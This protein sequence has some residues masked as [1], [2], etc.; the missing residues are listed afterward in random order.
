MIIIGDIKVMLT[1]VNLFM[2]WRIIPVVLAGILI[3]I[4]L[5]RL[6]ILLLKMRDILISSQTQEVSQKIIEPDK[7]I[8][9]SIILLLLADIILLITGNLDASID[10]ID[11]IEFPV[12]FAV[13]LV[14]IWLGYRLSERFF[15]IYLTKITRNGGKLNEDLLLLAKWLTLLLFLFIIITIFSETHE[16]NILGLIASL[17]VGGVAIAFA[18]QKTLEQLLGGI[19]LYFDRPFVLGDYVGLPDGTFG[20]VESIG[21]RSTKIRTSGKGSL[22]VVPNN[23][24]TGINIENFTGASKIISI[25]KM[26][27]S[28]HIPET[29][30]AF[31]H[32]L[33]LESSKN[34]EIDTHSITV[35]F[36]DAINDQG[37]KIS[38]SQIKYFMQS[39][40]ELSQE[41]RF[42]VIQIIIENIHQKLL[43]NGIDVET[44]ER[45]RID[46][47]ISI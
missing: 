2:N 40:R 25:V 43:E 26:N 19:V 41:F 39:S 30:Q 38:K 8:L 27:F 24:L 15:K 9:P 45:I 34:T 3:I 6:I 18:A 22:M 46:S 37:K 28:E 16:I 23:Y 20:R 10:V 47:Q 14:I 31:I 36:E 4:A 11:I 33:I 42:K 32:Q 21:L 44:V 17:G 12:G 7:D 29:K 5:P 35:N 13:S 1:A